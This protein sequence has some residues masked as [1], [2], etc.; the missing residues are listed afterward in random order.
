MYRLWGLRKCPVEA[1]KADTEP[2]AE[3]W[4]SINAQ[5]ARLW[6]NITLKKTPRRRERVGEGA[7]QGTIFLTKSW[8]RHLI[9]SLRERVFARG[10]FVMP[11]IWGGPIFYF[12]RLRAA[13]VVCNSFFFFA[14]T[15]G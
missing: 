3:K 11:D 5:Y 12:S 7:R 8:G 6:P 14:S 4:L 15:V 1:I 9:Q 10:H 2:G 13:S